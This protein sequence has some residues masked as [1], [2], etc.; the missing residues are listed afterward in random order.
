[1]KLRDYQ[2]SLVDQALKFTAANESP[3]IVSPTGSGKSVVI[4]E[5]IRQRVLRGDSL[6]IGCHRREILTHLIS[7]IKRHVGLSPDVIAADS[8]VKPSDM[9]APVCVAMIPTLTRRLKN[10]PAPWIGGRHLILDEAHHATSKSW[11]RLITTLDPIT[12]MGLT[13]TP[14]SANTTPLSAHFTTMVLGPESA[15]L[16]EMGFLAPIRVF[17]A[18][19]TIDTT[20]IRTRAGDYEITELANRAR[21]LSGKTVDLWKHY[22]EGRRTIVAACSIEH[23]KEIAAAFN[24]AG[25]PAAHADGSISTADR[26]QLFSDFAAGRLLV[27][28]QV[29]IVDEGL[30]IPA[31][32]CLLVARPTKSIR[33]RRQL[34]GR[35]RRIADG[36]DYAL[37]LD[38]TSGAHD[39]PLPD[40]SISWNLDKPGETGATPKKLNPLREERIRKPSGEVIAAP[41]SPERFREVL[42]EFQN[43]D[44]RSELATALDR[45]LAESIFRQMRY[46]R[47]R[48]MGALN[49]LRADDTSTLEHYEAVADRLGFSPLWPFL[50]FERSIRQTSQ[51]RANLE[52]HNEVKLTVRKALEDAVEQRDLLEPA[53]RVVE[54]VGTRGDLLMVKV[55]CN[56]RADYRQQQRDRLVRALQP[57]IGHWRLMVVG[58]GIL[59][60]ADEIRKEQ[61]RRQVDQLFEALP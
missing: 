3:L 8:K 25:I 24:R 58:H 29:S 10:L 56:I 37:L 11:S 32:S 35:I 9:T 53:L 36:K 52:L 50:E 55:T 40:E 39:L 23:S 21:K 45:G 2:Q 19:Q 16:V 38:Q 42:R 57:R 54:F 60:T 15:E 28:S 47:P 18:E 59:G 4:A 44:Q 48:R 17:A 12:T 20:G 61:H 33:L 14:V 7:S 27:I 43:W 30:D 49:A 13:A 46:S 41:L 31:A 51:R 22:A 1:M 6:L 26:D 5:I 34:E